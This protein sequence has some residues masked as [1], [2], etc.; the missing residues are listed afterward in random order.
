MTYG[1]PTEMYSQSG[2]E[3]LQREI[4]HFKKEIDYDGICQEIDED[5]KTLGLRK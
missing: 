3:L 4:E 2:I 5:I 1:S